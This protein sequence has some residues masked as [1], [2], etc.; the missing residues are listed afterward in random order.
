MSRQELPSSDGRLDRGRSL[1]EERHLGGQF[2]S[3]N[4]CVTKRKG[5]K[6]YGGRQ[7]YWTFSRCHDEGLN[8]DSDASVNSCQAVIGPTAPDWWGISAVISRWRNSLIP[9]LLRAPKTSLC[10]SSQSYPWVSLLALDRINYLSSKFQFTH[11]QA[12]V[13]STFLSAPQLL[14]FSVAGRGAELQGN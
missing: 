7:V 5:N 6:T 12:A 14:T 8:I 13:A 4:L 11:E 1:V 9:K 3:R 2:M 10:F